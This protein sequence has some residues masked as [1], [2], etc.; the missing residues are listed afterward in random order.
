MNKYKVILAAL[1][2]GVGFTSCNDF[3]DTLP[4]KRTE[5]N[6]AEHV[7]TL[8]VS[9][10]PQYLRAGFTEQRTD[11]ITDRGAEFDAGGV[12]T[13]QNYFW[14]PVT[15]VTQDTPNAFWNT[16]YSCASHANMALEAIEK[17]GGATKPELAPLQGEAL[18]CRAY[19]SYQLVSTFAHAYNS[20][21][22]KQDMG[23]P[24]LNELER[25][26]HNL[27]TKR[28]SVAENYAQIAADIEAAF[29][30][31]N[32][33][34]YA[35]NTN[36]V[37]YH[38][39]RRAAAAFAAEF[40]LAYEQPQKALEYA[41]I[42]LGDNPAASLRDWQVFNDLPNARDRMRRYISVDEPA[43]L[44]LQ[45]ASSGWLNALFNLR[46]AH[47]SS[48]SNEQTFNSPGPW[49]K[50]PL[51]H[52]TRQL[53]GR[54]MSILPKIFDIF[55][56]TNVQAGIGFRQ[57]VYVAYSV[58][59]ALLARAE[60][61]TLLKQYDKAAADL[62]MWYRSKGATKT[63]TAQQI[64]DY[65]SLDSYQGEDRAKMLTTVSKPLNPRF[66]EPLEAGMQTNLIH[67]VLH[68]RRIE[69][70]HEGSRWDDIKRYGIEITHPLEGAEALVLTAH[71]PRKAIQIPDAI[72]ASGVAPNPR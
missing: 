57:S 14:Q 32:D 29:P 9:A 25:N 35:Y 19:A 46:F 31:I 52:L 39:N 7:R 20:Q 44:L 67:A 6:S 54:G 64:S 33:A 24:S 60:A 47:S 23:V 26:I 70:L 21:T 38:F 45:P 1:A 69:T 15:N 5:L 66:A 41:N 56:Y 48:I 51:P 37:K 55:V 8:L 63:V 61:Y 27:S 28:L 49:G 16:L 53:F 71:D 34:I 18:M 68:A 4:D 42:V 59:K 11:N 40:Y 65:Y 10:Y 22:S 17:L 62:A 3:L 13:Q 36:V 58:D 30:L 43:N 50:Q 72:T 2:L 12:Q